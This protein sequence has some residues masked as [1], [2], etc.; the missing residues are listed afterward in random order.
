[1]FIIYFKFFNKKELIIEKIKEEDTYKLKRAKRNSR[2]NNNYN[3]GQYERDEF[4]YRNMNYYKN[5]TLQ[6]Q[7][8]SYSIASQSDSSFCSVKEAQIKL[9]EITDYESYLDENKC[10]EV[11][12]SAVADPQAFW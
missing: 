3:S 9:P 12:V 2:K 7:N 11:F 8:S 5:Q 4:N 10:A 6:S 1:M